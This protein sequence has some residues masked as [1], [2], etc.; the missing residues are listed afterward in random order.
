MADIGLNLVD[1]EKRP[2][3][4]MKFRLSVHFYCDPKYHQASELVERQTQSPSFS[5]VALLLDKGWSQPLT[6]LTG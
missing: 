2:V 4:M 6:H 5:G 1:C 3:S